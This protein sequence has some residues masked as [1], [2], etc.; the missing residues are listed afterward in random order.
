MSCTVFGSG[1][2]IGSVCS[3]V[4][5]DDSAVNIIRQVS[6]HL[7][8]LIDGPN[9]FLVRITENAGHGLYACLIEAKKTAMVR[10]GEF[11]CPFLNI[12]YEKRKPPLPC[13]LGIE[14]PEGSRSA[15]PR[16]GKCLFARNLLHPVDAVKILMLHIDLA[17]DLEISRDSRKRIHDIGN[18]A[19]IK[20]DI[21][22]DEPVPPGLGE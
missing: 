3:L 11:I 6:A 10:A 9:N 18:D 7:T 22:A 2:K 4:Y 19:R 12:K 17:S 8:D 16:V 20:R 21:L 13:H 5:L 1:R 15:V 14:L